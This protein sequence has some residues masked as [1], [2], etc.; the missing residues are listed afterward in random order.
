MTTPFLRRIVTLAPDDA[1]G[2]PAGV[3]RYSRLP[4]SRIKEMFSGV[5]LAARL[6]AVASFDHTKEY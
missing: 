3:G 6:P 5:K 1:L 4:A 2:I